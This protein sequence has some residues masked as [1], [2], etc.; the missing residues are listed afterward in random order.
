MK[1]V[2]SLGRGSEGSASAMRRSVLAPSAVSSI[3]R[4]LVASVEAHVRSSA[5][6]STRVSDVPFTVSVACS[7]VSC[8][9]ASV[10]PA[11]LTRSETNVFA[12]SET[13]A[14][15]LASASVPSVETTASASAAFDWV[16][17]AVSPSL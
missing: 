4:P 8:S 10:V 2:P 7:S 16:P 11:L 1:T 3:S 17:P 15:A 9:T 14:V 12:G 6:R 5:S 13:S